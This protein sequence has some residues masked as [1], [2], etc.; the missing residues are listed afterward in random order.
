MPWLAVPFEE[1]ALRARLG[2]K[3]GV[4][5]IP[6]LVIVGPN[7]EVSGLQP[8]WAA[9]LWYCAPG[10][11]LQPLAMLSSRP[12]YMHACIHSASLL[13]Q[14]VASDARSAVM[15][16][17]AGAKFPWRGSAGGG[18]G[19]AGWVNPCPLSCLVQGLPIK[20]LW[21]A[22]VGKPCCG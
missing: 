20:V 12:K 19:L 4:S 17:R 16:D 18:G 2:S 8:G 1:S 21:S 9:L 3:F 6:R 15:A 10:G 5:G 13:P 7:G 11:R 14:V 22:A